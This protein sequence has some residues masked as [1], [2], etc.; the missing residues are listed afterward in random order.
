MKDRESMILEYLKGYNQFDVDKMVADFDREF[1][2]ENITG[3]VTTHKLQGVE[4]FKDQAAQAAAYFSE[5]I[6]TAKSFV[7]HADK[8]EVEI[9]YYAVLALDFPTGEKA[10]EE[11]NM[12]GKSIFR[13]AD[14][15]I[16][17]ITDVS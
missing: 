14:D 2:F 5:R 12:G 8:T 3:G 7:H 1:V 13:F 9:D 17:G 16:I 15:K 6:Q 4:S 10:G 11:M